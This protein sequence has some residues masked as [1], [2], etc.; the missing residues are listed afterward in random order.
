VSSRAP[1]G[2]DVR[3]NHRVRS[4][5]HASLR[6]GAH[7]FISN[8]SCTTNCL[9][10]LVE[11]LAPD[12]RTGQ[13]PDDHPIHSYTNDQVAD[14]RLPRDL[15]RRAS[16]NPVDESRPKTGAATAVGL[17]MPEL[18]GRL[19]GYAIRVPTIKRVDRRPVLHRCARPQCRGSEPESMKACSGRSAARHPGLLPTSRWYRS[20]STTTPHSAVFDATLT[21]VSGRLVKVSSWYDQRVGLQQPDGWMS[22]WP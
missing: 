6:Q 3:C 14:R 5:T 17:V 10:P 15:R 11:A 2:K 22:R 8:A 16:A 9:A 12:D 13:R 21:K 18:A 7:R 20:T 19:D 1:G 4:P